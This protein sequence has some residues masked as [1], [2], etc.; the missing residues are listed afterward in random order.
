MVEETTEFTKEKLYEILKSPKSI[1]QKKSKIN[2]E[3][4]KKNKKSI[5][6]SINNSKKKKVQMKS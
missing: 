4:K 1:S 3:K 2:S 5:T 6:N